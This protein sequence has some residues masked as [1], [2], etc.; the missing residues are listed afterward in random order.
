MMMG[1]YPTVTPAQAEYFH[2]LT[3]VDHLITGALIVAQLCAATLLWLLRS[4]ALEVF[5]VAFLLSG[6]NLARHVATKNILDQ[7]VSL[8]VI[9]VVAGIMTMALGLLIPAAICAYVWKL[10]RDGVL[11]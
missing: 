5:L 3:W 11:H 10:R 6:A 2:N 1:Q 4:Q 7:F 9:G 8:G